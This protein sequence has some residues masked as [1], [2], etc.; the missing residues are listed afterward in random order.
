[1]S[2]PLSIAGLVLLVGLIAYGVHYALSSPKA[3]EH[4]TDS[5]TPSSAEAPAEE[6]RSDAASTQG[7]AAEPVSPT[8]TGERQGVKG[9][10]QSPTVTGAVTDSAAR[11][12]EG[13]VVSFTP[14]SLLKSRGVF[15]E[16]DVAEMS[17]SMTW[18]Q[19]DA[20]GRF[21][22]EL[23][24]AE[25]GVVWATARG[26][27]G[28][29]AWVEGA[30][31]ELKLELD[32]GQDITVTLR[33]ADGGALKGAQVIHRGQPRT[34][35]PLDRMTDAERAQQL[36]LRTESVQAD[37]TEATMHVPSIDGAHFVWGQAADGATSQRPRVE[38]GEEVALELRASFTL[39]VRV[40]DLVPT[41]DHAPKVVVIVPEGEELDEVYDL[42]PDG[43]GRFT[44]PLTTAP[45]YLVA[46]SCRDHALQGL[47]VETPAPGA[48]VQ[49]TFEPEPGN[50]Y[51]MQFVDV[52]GAPIENVRVGVY[53]RTTDGTFMNNDP[54]DVSN[55]DGIAQLGGVPAG[56]TF[57]Y[58]FSHD[59]F[60]SSS[61]GPVSAADFV[62]LASGDGYE[63]YVQPL[64]RIMRVTGEVLSQGERLKEYELFAWPASG[65]A[66]DR[67]PL[68]PEIDAEGRFSIEVPEQNTFVMAWA[69]GLPETERVL[70]EAQA[71][72]EHDLQLVVGP[73]AVGRGRL[74]EA[75]TLAPIEGAEVAAYIMGDAYYVGLSPD[76]VQTDATGRFQIEG[77]TA[78]RLCS[79]QLTAP[80]GRLAAASGMPVA[81]GSES[82][83]VD[84]G[85]ILVE[86]PGSIRLR[87]TGF[88]G[89]GRL[90]VSVNYRRDVQ[91]ALVPDDAGH[92]ALLESISGGRVA[93]E[94][95]E[96][97]ALLVR[98]RVMYHGEVELP[99]E[100]NLDPSTALQVG[101][102]RIENAPSTLFVEAIG[103]LAAG[104]RATFQTYTRAEDWERGAVT[105]QGLAPGSYCIKAF[106]E[107][108]ATHGL[109]TIEIETGAEHTIELEPTDRELTVRLIDEAGDPVAGAYLIAAPPTAAGTDA[110]YGQTGA[111]GVAYIGPVSFART[112]IRF[113]DGANGFSQWSD[114]AVPEDN[115]VIELQLARTH[116]LCFRV[117]DGDTPLSGVQV[118][119]NFA[120]GQAQ[121][122]V[123][124]TDPAGLFK[125]GPSDNRQ[126]L[127]EPTSSWVWPEQQAIDAT[128]VG[129]DPVSVQMRRRGNLEVLVRGH[130]GKPLA[131]VALTLTRVETQASVA[132]MLGPGQAQAG[133]SG[134]VT[135][136]EGTVSL[137]GLPHGS[138]AWSAGALGLVGSID[139]RPLDTTELIVDA[140]D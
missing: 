1:M 19:S 124:T 132:Q 126:Y 100:I 59:A 63:P 98:R 109:A 90:T 60:V 14:A 31:S 20:K 88:Q 137:T 50:V 47:P 52:D 106:D 85:D 104:G 5:A 87:V 82:Y 9:A 134:L 99:F 54:I 122:I 11:P 118:M 101:L 79:L 44:I 78:N 117:M 73:A 12:L 62:P 125:G 110:L 83:E 27:A 72:A 42:N 41:A 80:D 61:A 64:Q 119:T 102:S 138:Y 43:T 107:R 48:T 2:K 123:L 7:Q 67:H 36:F 111:D 18:G 74:L 8:T 112:A 6:R 81:S 69:R 127:I 114:I 57:Y 46:L 93:L 133:A 16:G 139:V 86:A 75:Q 129:A 91:Q 76:P 13:A 120:D 35:P 49:V 113:V 4:P 25:P 40:I 58:S 140:V 33:R 71:D 94:V 96:N 65:S 34:S 17:A 121:A 128:P 77:L 95:F 135:S 45:R 131:G 130:E 3:L 116:E 22:L 29:W 24:S 37:T 30:H 115:V 26:H 51:P 55:R 70:V 66:K 38:A 32:A 84:F 39:D 28:S 92:S 108:L 68:S 105:F 97:G 103:Q 10:L 56:A 15:S 136:A 23:D 21:A 89:E 53:A